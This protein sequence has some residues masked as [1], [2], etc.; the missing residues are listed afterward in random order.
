M[1]KRSEN[2][3]QYVPVVKDDEYLKAFEICY[4][5]YVH[6]FYEQLLRDCFK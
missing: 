3:C 4:R 2:V 6:V 5:V 1:R